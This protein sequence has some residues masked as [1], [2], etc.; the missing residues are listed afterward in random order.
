MISFNHVN[1]YCVSG[2][3]HDSVS[4]PEMHIHMV[5]SDG[6][7]AGAQLVSPEH[8]GNSVVFCGFP[9]SLMK[10]AFYP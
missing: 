5:P 6:N 7:C 3:D 1:L 8:E 4:E 10:V 2:A 9:I